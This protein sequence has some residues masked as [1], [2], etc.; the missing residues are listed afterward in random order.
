MN[1]LKITCL[2]FLVLAACIQANAQLVKPSEEKPAVAV[3]EVEEQAEAIDF[4]QFE[5]HEEKTEERF[6]IIKRD[7]VAMQDIA[8]YY[9]NTLPSTLQVA[10]E[11]GFN[12]IGMPYGLYFD[13]GNEKG[14]IDLGAGVLVEKVKGEVPG[15]I[16]Y[17]LP[18]SKMAVL[19]FYGD[20]SKLG[21]G[22]RVLEAYLKSKNLKIQYPVLEEYITDPSTEPDSNKWLTKIYYPFTR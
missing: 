5:I 2:S 12:I 1:Y 8:T 17:T 11:K 13:S 20:Y 18:S 7:K 14:I 6:Y 3:E 10:Q 22:H 19:N 15:F 4:D 21:D 16:V 9:G